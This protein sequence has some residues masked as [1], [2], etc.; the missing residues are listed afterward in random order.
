MPLQTVDRIWPDNYKPAFDDDVMTNFDHSIDAK[1][2]EKVKSGPHLG[3]YAAWEF[4][5]IVWW[6]CKISKWCCQVSQYHAV[7]ET[8]AADDLQEIMNYCCDE[9]G[10]A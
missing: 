9:Y 5:G 7:V 4:H 6:D 3:S 2:A 8:V 1:A 10:D